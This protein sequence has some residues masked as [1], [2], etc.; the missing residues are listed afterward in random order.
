M[1]NQ[2]LN[3]REQQ[4]AG[5]HNQ[6]S[7]L[8]TVE[9]NAVDIC[10]RDCSFCPQSQGYKPKKGFFDLDLMQKIANDLEDIEFNGRVTFTGFGEPL[11]YKHLPS[12][13]R[14]IKNTVSN[15]K[16]IEIVSNGDYLNYEKAKELDNAGCTNV[17][18]SMYDGDISNDIIP[19]FKDTNIELVLK[20]SYN[21][22]RTVN[23][24]EIIVKTND[25]DVARP[26]YLPFYK[27]MIDIDGHALICAN[28]WGRVGIVGNVYKETLK[29][30]WLGSTLNFY[31]EQLLQGKRERCLPCKFCNINGTL[32]GEESVKFWRN[33]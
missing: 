33:K 10:N 32:H 16:W 23:R 12:A 11:L 26:C 8:R 29:D 7:A 27:M 4:S 28:D 21:G 25:L 6:I 20:D 22:F 2:H 24:N 5:A 19:M 17:T 18:V 13:I 14:I 30:I 3:L 15:I 9:I 31:R 1:S